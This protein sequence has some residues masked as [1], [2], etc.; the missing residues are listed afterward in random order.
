MEE[1]QIKGLSLAKGLLG[2]LLF[3]SIFI[4]RFY[5]RSV[6]AFYRIDFRAEDLLLALI[7]LLAWGGGALR[8]GSFPE[9]SSAGKAFLGFLI[10]AQISIL[11]GFFFRT[12]D[13]PFLSLLYLAKWIEYFLVFILTLRLA[14][15][16]KDFDHFLK[17]FFLLGIA[18]AGFGYWEHFFPSAKAVYPNYYRLF[19]RPPFRGDAN[20][21]GGLLVLW[22]GFFT[23]LFLKTEK[24]QLQLLL[25][26]S[27]LF[28]FFPFIWTYS[29]KSYFALAGMFIFLL[30]VRGTRKRLLFLASIL[31]ILGLGL[32]TRLAER[33]TDLGEAFGSTDP[34]HSSW[35]G[36]WVMWKE[37]FWNFERFFLFGSG[38]GSRHRLFYES[39]YILV[40]AETGIVGFIAFVFLGLSLVREIRGRGFCSGGI[41]EQGL[42][43]GWLSGFVGLL[44][45]NASCVSW[46]VAKIALPF[47]FLTALVLSRLRQV[48]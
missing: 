17:I 30:L 31:V 13:K 27:V 7:V 26:L 29:R 16:E 42:A 43:L 11:N 20:H 23:G 1:G 18:I 37:A 19:E 5:L 38:L 48:S 32:P 2:A 21:I 15:G 34:F 45:H 10:A 22:I 46:T 47:W 40:L 35:A 24:R 44:I 14:S 36:N 4:P 9:V 33:L 28:V 12:I 3:A 39:Q 8:R 41:R 25:P 6:S